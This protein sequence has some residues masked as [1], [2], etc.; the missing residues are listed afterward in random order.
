M[1]FYYNLFNKRAREAKRLVMEKCFYCNKYSRDINIRY[2]LKIC[3]KCSYNICLICHENTKHLYCKKC[4]II[5]DKCDLYCNMCDIY[6]IYI[7]NCIIPIKN[8]YMNINIL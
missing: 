8:K 6:N 2:N 4:E 7:H 3:F 5:W 1:I